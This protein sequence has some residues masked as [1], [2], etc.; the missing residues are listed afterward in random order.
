MTPDPQIDFDSFPP[1]FPEIMNAAFLTVRL[2]GALPS[3]GTPLFVRELTEK[4]PD[5]EVRE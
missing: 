4:L 2:E 3:A 5:F 1:A